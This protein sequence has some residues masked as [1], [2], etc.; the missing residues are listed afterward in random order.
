MDVAY[1][2]GG[3]RMATILEPQ[4]YSV[5]ETVA[6]NTLG[7]IV[8]ESLK[9]LYEPYLHHT[10]DIDN[11]KEIAKRAD[12]TLEAQFKIYFKE[13][14]HLKGK[15]LIIFEVAK[16]Y[17]HNFIRLETDLLK[18]GNT[19]KIHALE[20]DETV[21][22]T[23]SEWDN[24]IILKGQIDRIDEYNGVMRIIDYK[25]GKVENTHLSLHDWDLL[26][27]DYKKYGKSLQV[28]FYTY[29]LYKNEKLNLP[30]ETGV[31]S[32]KNLKSGFLNFGLKENATT[33]KRETAVTEETMENF[34]SQL[35]RLLLELLDPTIPF[36]ENEI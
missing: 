23:L 30:V 29:M 5:E 19:I 10:L 3:Y 12:K 2:L 33:R 1:R 17:V 13:G 32:F 27:S 36:T 14:N 20:I 31:I 7:T 21:T 4:L 9:F 25:T 16:R 24:P 15:N 11:L 28:L 18:K 35:K 22:I 34:E 26:P 6:A 8:H